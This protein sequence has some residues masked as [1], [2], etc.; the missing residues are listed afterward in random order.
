M[1]KDHAGGGRCAAAA[2]VFMGAV[3]QCASQARRV[4]LQSVA[5][6]SSGLAASAV[7]I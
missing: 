2:R 3:W 4:L 6:P 1:S 7:S 5:V